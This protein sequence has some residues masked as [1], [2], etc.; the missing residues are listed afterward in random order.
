MKVGN[1]GGVRV[2]KRRDGAVAGDPGVQQFRDVGLVLQEA[3]RG[4]EVVE[5]PAEAAIVEIDDRQAVAVDEQIGEPQV[6]MDEAEM[7]RGPRHRRRAAGAAAAATSSS[8]GRSVRR[9]AEPSRQSPQSGLS[10]S[11]VLEIPGLADEARRRR[12]APAMGMQPR[13]DRAEFVE[14][15]G[16]AAR[17]VRLLA[18]QELEGDD[19]AGGAVIVDIGD[20]RAV[21]LR[22]RG[23]RLDDAVAVQRGEPGQLGGDL[24][25]RMIAGP[26]DAEDDVA[27]PLPGPARGRW[28]FRKPSAAPAACPRPKPQRGRAARKPLSSW[29]MKSSLY[30]RCPPLRP[31]SRHRRFISAFRSASAMTLQ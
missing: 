15:A 18:G 1:D 21:G 11:V 3:D 9:E 6:G 7:S 8:I 31:A 29:P 5:I 10:P 20:Q 2:R 16:Q 12:P 27:A 17:L 30:I 19:M 13:A 23:E 28:R 14:P 26:M 24:L 4:G 22:D 25:A